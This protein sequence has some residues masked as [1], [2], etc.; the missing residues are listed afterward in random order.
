MRELL[1]CALIAF[2]ACNTTPRIVTVEPEWSDEA[3]KHGM[4]LDDLAKVASA[5]AS[6]CAS[7]AVTTSNMK[8]ASFAMANSIGWKEM[9]DVLIDESNH[10]R[11]VYRGN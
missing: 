2:G 11:I 5:N 4:T 6:Y 3:F 9:H 10:A 8:L 7:I 1:I